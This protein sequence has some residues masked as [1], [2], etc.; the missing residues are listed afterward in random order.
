MVSECRAGTFFSCVIDNVC[1]HNILGNQG[2]DGWMDLAV[3]GP[4]SVIFLKKNIH[5]IFFE[6]NILNHNIIS[7]LFSKWEL[8]LNFLPKILYEIS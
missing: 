6:R 2:M 8:F 7:V 5:A 3:G 1:F 4:T